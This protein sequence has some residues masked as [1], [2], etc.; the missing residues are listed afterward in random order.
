MEY[1][2]TTENKVF[3]TIEAGGKWVGEG[4]V[5]CVLMGTEG[6]LLLW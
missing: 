5:A 6:V 3:N 4:A 2:Q 1:A